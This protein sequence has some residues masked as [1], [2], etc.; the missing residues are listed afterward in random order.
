MPGCTQA[1]E[2]C[3]QRWGHRDI[4]FYGFGRFFGFCTNNLRFFGLGISYRLQFLFCFT[5]SFQFFYLMR[6]GV[7]PISLWSICAAFCLRF[8]VL[9]EIYFG[10]VVFY[11]FL[12]GFVVSNVLQFHPHKDTIQNVTHHPF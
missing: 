7:L 4:K 3:R 12:Y 1:R 10:F 9:I 5:P 2:P 6:F 11:Y 8:S